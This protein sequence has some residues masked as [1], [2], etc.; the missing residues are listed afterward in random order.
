MYTKLKTWRFFRLA[1]AVL[2]PASADHYLKLKCYCPG[3]RNCPIIQA[4][5]GTLFCQLY[6]LIEP[7]RIYAAAQAWMRLQSVVTG[8]YEA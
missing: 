1:S 5:T 2:Y 7:P 3:V 8:H 4:A 6:Y